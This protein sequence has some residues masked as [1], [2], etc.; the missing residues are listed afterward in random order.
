MCL[1][2]ASATSLR[3]LATLGATEDSNE[4]Q[5]VASLGRL[6]VASEGAVVGV[7]QRGSECG[8]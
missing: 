5:L 6:T 3:L 1:L 2:P 4:E 7:V 8:T